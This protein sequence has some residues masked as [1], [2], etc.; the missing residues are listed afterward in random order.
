MSACQA[1]GSWASGQSSSRS[2]AL[3]HVFLTALHPSSEE[4]VAGQRARRLCLESREALLEQGRRADPSV[5]PADRTAARAV[6]LGPPTPWGRVLREPPGQ[7]GDPRCLAGQRLPD[8]RQVLLLR[9]CRSKGHGQVRASSRE[10]TPIS[11]RKTTLRG[12]RPPAPHAWRGDWV[13]ARCFYWYDGHAMVPVTCQALLLARHRTSLF[14]AL[15]AQVGTVTNPTSQ[16][17]RWAPRN[18]TA[19]VWATPRGVCSACPFRVDVKPD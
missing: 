6:A 18:P 11:S 15:T 2:A 7:D 16:A 3:G 19:G 12:F 9:L 4:S 10:K 8:R 14:S 17:R 13:C 5:G 1:Q